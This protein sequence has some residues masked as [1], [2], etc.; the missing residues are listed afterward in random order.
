MFSTAL[1]YSSISPLV[2]GFATVGFTLIYL[3]FRYNALF[4]LGTTVSTNGESYA[5]ALQQLTVG[6]YLSEICLIGL[7]AIGSANNTQAIG[8]LVILVVLLAATIVAH[9]FMNRNLDKIRADL[10]EGAGEIVQPNT[11]YEN[12][13]DAEKLGG[14]NGA[15]SSYAAADPHH[16][17]GPMEAKQAN[18]TSTTSNQ[19]FMSRIKGYFAPQAAAAHAVDKISPV[20]ATPARPYTQREEAEAYIHPAI[21][22]ECPVVWIA[23]DKYGVS[24]QEIATTRAKVGEGLEISDECAWFNDKGKVEWDLNNPDK[25]PIYEDLPAY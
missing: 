25:A 5:R 1:S 8:P 19:S 15:S 10:P 17:E 11:I 18:F 22:S 20:L 12:D 6:V 16:P 4:T 7:L 9:V 13:A 21:T 2:L 14:T 24:Q 23:R 3:G